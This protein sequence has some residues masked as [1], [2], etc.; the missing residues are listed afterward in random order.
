VGSSGSNGSSY[1]GGGSSSGSDGGGCRCHLCLPLRALIWQMMSHCHMTK[2]MTMQCLMMTLGLLGAAVAILL[3]RW[4]R[5][6]HC[7]GALQLA[8][9]F[10]CH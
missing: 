2:M 10:L 9:G 1:S 3:L 6:Q 8:Q 7:A 5:Q 4:R